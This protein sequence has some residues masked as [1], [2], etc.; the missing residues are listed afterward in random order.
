M[1]SIKD[2]LISEVIKIEGGYVNDPLDSGGETNFGITVAVAREN[3][4]DGKMKDMPKV[5]AYEIYKRRYWDRLTLDK[6]EPI[7]EKIAFELFDTGVNMGT[8][9]PCKF[10]QR[11][12]NALGHKGTLELKVDGYIGSKTI[13]ALKNVLKHRGANG[14]KVILRMLNALQGAR[15]IEITEKYQKNKRFTF[16]WFLNRVL[17]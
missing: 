8:S 3:G 12:L 17:I 1:S 15:Y 6:I 7:S 4:Y 16:G 2:K 5:V 11:S 9:I 14:E 13:L 10:L